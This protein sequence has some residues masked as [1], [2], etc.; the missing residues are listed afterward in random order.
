[1]YVYARRAARNRR[2]AV[3]DLALN[4]SYTYMP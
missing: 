1:V 3:S 2:I 4:M